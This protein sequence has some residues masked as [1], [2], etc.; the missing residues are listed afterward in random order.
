MPASSPDFLRSP[1]VFACGTQGQRQGVLSK[2]TMHAQGTK[3]PADT[4]KSEMSR[5]A[6]RSAYPHV[7]LLRPPSGPPLLDTHSPLAE[8]LLPSLADLQ[9]RHNT[10]RSCIST[11][12]YTEAVIHRTYRCMQIHAHMPVLVHSTQ[13]HPGSHCPSTILCW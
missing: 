3:T 6:N 2:E 11:E 7:L 10:T 8:T 12:H 13:K 4:S 9:K 5:N 1:N